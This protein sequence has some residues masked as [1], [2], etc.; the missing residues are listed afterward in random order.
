MIRD[1]LKH[2]DPRLY[3]K[4]VPVE[5]DI[6]AAAVVQDLLDT[7]ELHNG[8]GLAAPQIGENVRVVVIKRNNGDMLALVNPRIVKRS[9]ITLKS[10][11]QCLSVPEKTAI[12]RRSCSVTV[13]SEAGDIVLKDRESC[14]I[15]HECDHL[16]GLL[17][18]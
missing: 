12:I 8:L 6:I 17:I 3:E 11:E 15:Q 18:K 10:V 7:C 14:V 1:I 5:D 9:G 4:S 2:P 13:T 16:E